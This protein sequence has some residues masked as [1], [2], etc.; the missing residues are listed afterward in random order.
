MRLWVEL[1]LIFAVACTP[2]RATPPSLQYGSS[3]DVEEILRTS[4]VTVTELRCRN[5]TEQGKVTRGVACGTSLSDA[6]ISALVTNLP[7]VLGRPAPY[8]NE[9]NCEAMP[10][11]RSTDP[12]VQVL[13]GK[14]TKVPSGIGYVELH[15]A[16][17][18]GQACI[19]VHY[20]WS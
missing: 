9:H 11:L 13:V 15:V 18:T 8:G 2:S 6:Q 4:G 1:A 10:G 3:G 7:L 5:P 20:P 12:G 17:S 19:E 14:N 16:R